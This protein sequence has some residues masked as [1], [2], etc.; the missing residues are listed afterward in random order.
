MKVD[1][2]SPIKEEPLPSAGQ[3]LRE[4]RSKLWDDRIETPLLAAA[5]GVALAA[6]EWWRVVFPSPPH[7]WALTLLALG[8]TAFFAW[9]LYKTLPAIRRLKLAEQGERAVGQELEKLR[10]EGY[11]VFHDVPGPAFNIDHVLIGPSGIVCV[12]TKTWSKPVATK[13][14]LAFD[15]ETVTVQPTGWKPSRDPV[16]QVR[17]LADWLQALLKQSAGREFFVRPALLFPGWWVEQGSGTTKEIWVLEPK[18]LAGFL[19]HDAR[20]LSPEDLNLATFHLTRY[21]RSATREED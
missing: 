3:S 11:I 2:R 20:R 12:E 16:L 6:I 1:T 9:R 7:P 10:A 8:A 5:V 15:G 14:N 21:I 13:A 18:A 4:R 19:A 17:A